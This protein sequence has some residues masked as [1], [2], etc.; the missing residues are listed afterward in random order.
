MTRLALLLSLLLPACSTQ[1]LTAEEQAAPIQRALN[2][3]PGETICTAGHPV[4][5]STWWA[6][7]GVERGLGADRRQAAASR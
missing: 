3:S 6:R 2:G 4:T 5:C 7:R 1:P